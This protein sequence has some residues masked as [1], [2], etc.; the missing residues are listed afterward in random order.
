M[1]ADSYDDG[2]YGSDAILF[3][4]RPMHAGEQQDIREHLRAGSVIQAWLRQQYVAF[5][6]PAARR[7]VRER[8]YRPWFDLKQTRCPPLGV[9]RVRGLVIF[10]A[11]LPRCARSTPIVYSVLPDVVAAPPETVVQD[12]PDTPRP[13]RY[14]GLCTEDLILLW[15]VSESA[16]DMLWWTGNKG[17]SGIYARASDLRAAGHKLKYM[18]SFRPEEYA[19]FV[20][21]WNSCASRDEVVERTG[22]LPETATN[23]AWKMR[24]LG[25]VMKDFSRNHSALRVRTSSR[26]AR[27]SASVA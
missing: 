12:T 4:R 7:F 23:R 2:D 5:P 15:N 24:K 16:R 22:L 18:R 3:R 8:P 14:T 21:L 6:E 13:N 17:V 20:E 19:D 25:Y 11:P 26:R 9:V 10:R 27:K 1:Q